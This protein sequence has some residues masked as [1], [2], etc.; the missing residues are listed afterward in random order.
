M[1]QYFSIGNKGKLKKFNNPICENGEELVGKGKDLYDELQYC[2]ESDIEDIM[3]KTEDPE[4]VK[5]RQLKRLLREKH[6][7]LDLEMKSGALRK[8]SRLDL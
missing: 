8:H 3:E 4:K 6:K 5:R 2:H 1:R 7:S